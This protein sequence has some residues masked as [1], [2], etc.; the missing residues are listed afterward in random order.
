VVGL[1]SSEP[2]D[3]LRLAASL[4]QL[5]S[6][7]YAAPI[8]SAAREQGM[9]L[10]FPTDVEE[11]PGAGVEGMVD[12]HSVRLGKRRWASAGNQVPAEADRL[13]RRTEI[14]G[15]SSVF[16]AL[17]GVVAGA[18]LLEDSIRPDTPRAIRTLRQLGIRSVVMITGDHPA[19][20]ASIGEAIGADR[21]LAER[22]PAEKVEAVRLERGTGPTGDGWRWHQ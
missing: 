5:S 14:E 19:V 10:S 15:T 6:H 1:G 9:R 22:S 21:V 3:I 12:G 13:A 7:P 4:E 8:V 16:V 17:D 11:A 18:L 20:A 2:D